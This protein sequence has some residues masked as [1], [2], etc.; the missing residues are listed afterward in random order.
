MTI[1]D[2]R[3]GGMHAAAAQPASPGVRPTVRF[4]LV[5]AVLAASPLAAQIYRCVED[6]TTIFSDRPCS[7]DSEIHEPAARLS[8]IAAAQDLETVRERN[9]E[10]ID[11]RLD[12]IASARERAVQRPD[13]RQTDRD[14]LA[15][16]VV[17][18]GFGY[19]VIAPFRRDFHDRKDRDEDPVRP[20][21]RAPV[22]EDSWTLSGRQLG[23]RRNDDP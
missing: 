19:P 10:F 20:P 13:S 3:P 7:E 8:V 6:E 18:R 14:Q 16:P 23:S 9:R 17:N 15:Y 22:S 21:R 11:Q 5:L 12:R 1:M 2:T 4:L